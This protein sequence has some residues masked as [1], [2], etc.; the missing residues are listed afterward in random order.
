MSRADRRYRTELTIARRV[1]CNRI[2]FHYA[3][4]VSPHEF[5][6]NDPTG[7]CGNRGCRICSWERVWK[8][9]NKKR[10]RIEGHRAETEA[11]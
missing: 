9:L 6:K 1:E 5:H 11:A 3:A 7:A 4:Q 2:V 10:E 8:R